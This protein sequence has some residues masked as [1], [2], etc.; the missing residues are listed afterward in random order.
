VCVCVCVCAFLCA[1]VC[2]RV[3]LNFLLSLACQHETAA[4]GDA[5]VTCNSVANDKSLYRI[6]KKLIITSGPM[7]VPA[8]IFLAMNLL[9]FVSKSASFHNFLSGAQFVCLTRNLLRE[10]W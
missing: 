6:G 4:G 2:V 9:S 3:H 8:V 10:V 7:V 5:A 1:C